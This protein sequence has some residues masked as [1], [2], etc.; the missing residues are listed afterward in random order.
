MEEHEEQVMN[1]PEPPE[2]N[3]PK[4]EPSVQ[5]VK[6][7]LGREERWSR[8]KA[9]RRGRGSDRE[10][11]EDKARDTENEGGTREGREGRR[12]GAH[13]EKKEVE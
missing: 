9:V 3:F 6:S 12:P 5:M 7:A 2:P 8:T 10:H 1:T 4:T 11:G 13:V